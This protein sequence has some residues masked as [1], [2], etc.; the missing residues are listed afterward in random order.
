M[1]HQLFDYLD[2]EQD[3]LKS[4]KSP[5]EER[6]YRFYQVVTEL[7][8][9]IDNALKPAIDKKQLEV[10]DVSV[11]QIGLMSLEN[12]LRYTAKSQLFCC[13]M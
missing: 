13:Q 4:K 3:R 11:D 5:V 10:S 9:Q 7:F 8:E 6:E 12:R 1:A 2:K